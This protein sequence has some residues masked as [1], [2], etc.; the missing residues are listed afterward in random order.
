M[1]ELVKG[2]PEPTV[3][4]NKFPT[5][6]QQRALE[7]A[8]GQWSWYAPER[9]GGYGKIGYYDS[10]PGPCYGVDSPGAVF[11][12]VSFDGE[13]IALELNHESIPENTRTE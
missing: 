3:I 7:R 10:V 11:R 4:R 1:I 12:A 8:G 5:Q 6:E 13:P 9:I 2:A